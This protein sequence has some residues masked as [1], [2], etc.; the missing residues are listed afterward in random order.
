MADAATGE[1][2]PHD[3]PIVVHCEYTLDDVR[4]ANAA[5]RRRVGRNAWP[6][7][8]IYA[9]FVVLV[10]VAVAFLFRSAPGPAPAAAPAGG[11]SSPWDV[12]WPLIPWL[13]FIPVALFFARWV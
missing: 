10:A 6:L 1:L 9:G 11:S 3:A 7:R 8:I 2:E 5:V 12:L 4:E 13:I